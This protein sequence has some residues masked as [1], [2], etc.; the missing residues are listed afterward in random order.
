MS[1]GVTRGFEGFQ[2]FQGVSRSLQGVSRG[3]K[4]FYRVSRGL[5]AREVA[6]QNKSLF[7][8]SSNSGNQRWNNITTLNNSKSSLSIGNIYMQETTSFTS[9]TI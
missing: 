3:F 9:F 4:G 6:G 1:R 2:G 8:N 5:G 7:L